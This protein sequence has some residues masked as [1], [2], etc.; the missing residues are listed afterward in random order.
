MIFD[1][2]RGISL[3]G[4]VADA[5]QSEAVTHVLGTDCCLC[6]WARQLEKMAHPT[7]FEPVTF[8]IG[9][10]HSIQLSYGCSVGLCG[11]SADEAV[12]P[13]TRF[14]CN[15]EN[16]WNGSLPRAFARLSSRAGIAAGRGGVAL[17]PAIGRR[18]LR[19]RHTFSEYICFLVTWA[20]R[21]VPLRCS[22]TMTQG[23]VGN[24][25]GILPRSGV[26]GMA[27]ACRKQK[28]GKH[29]HRRQSIFR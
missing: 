28:P 5:P 8:G 20:V 3:S 15:R 21:L 12:I 22:C 4:K 29:I 26:G 1:S 11:R 18:Y 13:Q 24:A 14:A 7:G 16:E 23:F 19:K 2:Y 27:Q 25:C 10:Q 6:L 17:R 9:I